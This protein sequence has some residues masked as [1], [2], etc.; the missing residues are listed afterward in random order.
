LLKRRTNTQRRPVAAALLV[1][2]AVAGLVGCNRNGDQQVPAPKISQ[3]T[4]S[5]GQA[6]KFFSMSS[7]LKRDR[8]QSLLF[9]VNKE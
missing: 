1:A 9:N 4:G 5:S 7:Q 2:A 6:L 8:A 3:A